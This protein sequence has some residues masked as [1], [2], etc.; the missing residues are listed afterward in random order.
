MGDLISAQ[1]VAL[2]Q[3]AIKKKENKWAGLKGSGQVS[4]DGKSDAFMYSSVEGCFLQFFPQLAKHLF[5]SRPL[6]SLSSQS[7]WRLNHWGFLQD[8]FKASLSSSKKRK[9]KNKSKDGR[10]KEVC[11]GLF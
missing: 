7:K 4:I 1:G 6:E 3:S 5:C 10:R 2:S 11:G 9:K 8:Q